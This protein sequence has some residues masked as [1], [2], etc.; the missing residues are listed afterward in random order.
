MMFS[1]LS[2]KTYI[3]RVNGANVSASPPPSELGKI[4]VIYET[5]PLN[6]FH[7]AGYFS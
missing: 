1:R 2:N 3:V 7:L 5:T 4:E 6:I